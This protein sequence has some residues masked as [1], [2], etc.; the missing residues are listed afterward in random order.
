[1]FIVEQRYIKYRSFTFTFIRH[2]AAEHSC[3]VSAVPAA[4]S[5]FAMLY[6]EWQVMMV[7]SPVAEAV[8]YTIY[9]CRDHHND[10]HCDVRFTAYTSLTL[11]NDN[12]CFF[13]VGGGVV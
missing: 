6:N 7:W 9:W 11:D 13:L 5:Q 10:R 4:P 2:C 1:M 12:S 8:G 3:C